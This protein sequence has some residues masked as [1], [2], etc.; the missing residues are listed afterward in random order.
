[1]VSV[2]VK[3]PVDVKHHVYS[4]TIHPSIHP[5]TPGVHG[6]GRR[7]GGRPAAAAER[8][9][10]RWVRGWL[11]GPGLPHRPHL[12]RVLHLP[13]PSRADGGSGRGRADPAAGAG[14]GCQRLLA[15][16]LGLRGHGRRLLP[17]PEALHLGAGAPAADGAR[18]EL[19]VRRAVLP[20]PLRGSGG[21]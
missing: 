12:R 21:Q 9:P 2:D 10:G 17:G 1:M 7:G 19:H 8:L 6:Q 4:L 13:P 18:L 3:H 20:V 5:S 14:A 11:R 16:R 15:V